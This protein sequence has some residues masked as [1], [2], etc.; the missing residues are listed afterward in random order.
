VLLDKQLVDIANLAINRPDMKGEHD[1]FN[2]VM[3]RD[4]IGVV[5]FFE[6]LYTGSRLIVVNTHIFWDIRFEDVKVVQVAILMEQVA[7]LAEKYAKWPPAVDKALPRKLSDETDSIQIDDVKLLPSQKYSSGTSIPLVLCGD[8]NAALGSVVYELLNNS[9][10]PPTHDDLA[11]RR[12][13]NFTRNGITHPFTLSSA[14]SQ[15]GE[16]PFTD[17]TAGFT[18]ITDWIWYSSNQLNTIGLLGEVDRT[19]LERVPGFPNWNFPSDHIALLSEFVIKGSRK[20]KTENDGA[21]KS[22]GTGTPEAGPSLGRR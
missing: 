7:K 14:Y 22:T 13:G 8:F 4:N 16:L 18:G 2:R 9:S 19:Y 20:R 1:I 3:P 10:I 21:G 12:Y 5:A 17:H 15:I 6:N 11:G